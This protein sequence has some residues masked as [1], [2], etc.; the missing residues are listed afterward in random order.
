MT[1]FLI[2]FISLKTERW[3]ERLHYCAFTQVNLYWPQKVALKRTHACV[4]SRLMMIE[5]GYK[6]PHLHL[7]RAVE[8]HY[9]FPPCS[10]QIP[11]CEAVASAFFHLPYELKSL[12]CFD[13]A[14]L[15]L[16]WLLL[17]HLIKYP[18]LKRIARWIK[19]LYLCLSETKLANIFINLAKQ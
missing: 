4:F 16:S 1:V 12:S 13:S 9:N 5:Y 10:S 17:T 11:V 2:Y 3:V 19:R 14:A 8:A 6:N 18:R 15:S 7:Q